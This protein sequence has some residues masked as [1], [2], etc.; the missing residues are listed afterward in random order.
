MGGL[1]PMIRGETHGRYS[2]ADLT[3][4][5]I[6]PAR[7]ATD[8]SS[9]GQHGSGKRERQARGRPNRIPQVLAAALPAVDPEECEML[10][11]YDA[12]GQIDGVLVRYV[13]SKATVACFELS[14][15]TRLVAISGQS[16]VLFERRG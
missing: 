16:G 4:G 8:A 14:D 12:A 6:E 7:I 13:L 2:V 5:R 15:L 10:Y 9:F 3:V 11:E 1:G